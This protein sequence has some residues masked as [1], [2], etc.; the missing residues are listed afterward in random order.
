MIRVLKILLPLIAI[1]I[2]LFPATTRASDPKIVV[3]NS[4]YIL[5][6]YTTKHNT[7]N[8]FGPHGIL[9]PA[10]GGDIKQVY[11]FLHGNGSYT[12]Q[13]ICN[14]YI[15]SSFPKLI[16]S[17]GNSAIIFPIGRNEND[18]KLTSAEIKDYLNEA[19]DKLKSLPDI[20]NVNNNNLIV[21]GHSGAGKSISQYLSHGF[22]A[23]KTIVFDGCYSN[24]CNQ[25]VQNKNAGQIYLYY[26]KSSEK[27]K[28]GTLQAEKLFPGIA[29]IMEVDAEHGQVPQFC[30][31]EHIIQDK[32]QSRGTLKS[33]GIIT[34]FGN[35][36]SGTPTEIKTI[37]PKLIIKIPQLQFTDI[38]STT[39]DDAGYINI[40]W[41]GEYIEAVYNFL[42][43]T[44]SIIGVVIILIRGAKIVVSGGKEKI[45][46]YKKIGRIVV[47]LFLVWG[48]YLI[49]YTINPTLTNLKNLKVK[50]I[51]PIPLID[52]IS[53]PLTDS[54]T[55]IEEGAT[56][57]GGV[58]VKDIKPYKPFLQF[59][60]RWGGKIYGYVNKGCDCKTDKAICNIVTE[61]CCTNIAQAGCGPTALAVVLSAYGSSATPD[62][63]ADF[64]GKK[65][66]GRV[67]N[68]GTSLDVIIAKLSSSPWNNFVGEKIKKE[69]ALELINKNVPIIFLCSGCTGQNKN[70]GTKK[71]NGHYMVL[72]GLDGDKVSVHDVG[73]SELLGISTMTTKQL[74]ANNGFW[75]IRPR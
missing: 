5:Y 2:A 35:G 36:P 3:S 18:T 62:H 22:Q 52:F 19:F 70:G 14:R 73:G 17:L 8:F 4:D 71:Y 40:P 61:E 47:G 32:C 58:I 69:R 42:I 6:S 10:S 48:S 28:N 59:D 37:K 44:A 50:Y 20:T 49:I 1:L 39:I 12:P 11:L 68:K 55:P 34:P 33:T 43:L 25:I 67:C 54:S 9:V 60:K 29:Q 74:D 56:A 27:T 21:T 15:C 46:E 13:T 53:E 64:A 31:L 66:N 16:K 45:E 41:M 51:E 24:W 72:T 30:F 57:D 38:S 63:T 65:G 7:A 23:N 75:Y 26:I